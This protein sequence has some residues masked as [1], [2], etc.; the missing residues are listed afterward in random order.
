MR[1]TYVQQLF[2]VNI[3]LKHALLRAVSTVFIFIQW[4]SR[5]FVTNGKNDHARLLLPDVWDIHNSSMYKGG[6][7]STPSDRNTPGTNK[8]SSSTD[9]GSAP[10]IM[11]DLSGGLP[12]EYL[13]A[14]GSRRPASF[15]LRS[16]WSKRPLNSESFCSPKPKLC[17]PDF[18]KVDDGFDLCW[19]KAT[20]NRTLQKLHQS[21]LQGSGTFFWNS[22][23]VGVVIL[24]PLKTMWSAAAFTTATLRSASKTSWKDKGFVSMFPAEA[25]FSSTI[26]FPNATKTCVHHRAG[27]GSDPTHKMM[28][29]PNP[30]QE[31]LTTCRTHG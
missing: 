12:I 25:F 9:F 6:L 22:F 29:W 13:C 31:T 17:V 16:C 28:G 26:S 27:H 18:F 8:S 4:L 11:S 21:I 19:Q 20:K 5:T 1:L 30:S 7:K 15:I 24:A 3:I 10:N 2:A 23:P 14:N